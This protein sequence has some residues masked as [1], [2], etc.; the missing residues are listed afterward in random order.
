MADTVTRTGMTFSVEAFRG[1][2]I[3]NY[4]GGGG[5][6]YGCCC[7]G[8]GLPTGLNFWKVVTPHGMQGEI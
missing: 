4:K 2:T 7:F 5:G 8:W 6:P 1:T 3:Q